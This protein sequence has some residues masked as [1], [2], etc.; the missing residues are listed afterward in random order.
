[1]D[2]VVERLTECFPGPIERLQC[3]GRA[4]RSTPARGPQHPRR[5]CPPPRPLYGNGSGRCRLKACPCR[6]SSIA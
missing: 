6:R 1:V 3:P 4:E 2:Q 5:R